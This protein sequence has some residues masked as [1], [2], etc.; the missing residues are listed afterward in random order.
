MESGSST[1]GAD[2]WV[3]RFGARLATLLRPSAALTLLAGALAVQTL[4]ALPPR[5]VCMVLLVAALPLA[6]A[7]GRTRWL[8]VALLGAAWT[9]LRADLALSRRLAPEL[10]GADVVL[11]GAVHGL[12]RVGEDG[13]HFALA[14]ERAER[15][16]REFVLDGIVRLGWYD[17]APA[18]EPCARWRLH[19][20]LKR[21]RGMIDP[22]AFD[23][24]RYALE[25]GIVAT[26]YV[27][28]DAVNHAV[29]AAAFCIDRLRARIGET[30][31][32]TLGDT[33]SAHLLR[34]LAF[35]DQH[36]MDEHEWAV[37]RATGI[38]HL[39]AISG[40]HIALFASFGVGLMRLLWKLAPRLTL[41]WPAP[42]LEAIASLACAVAYALI[43]GFGLPTRRAL[44][45]IAALLVANLARRAR[46]PV[47][48]LALAVI[49]L[50]AWDPLCVL[51][52][53]FWLSFVGVAWLLFC[54]GGARERRRWWR[55]LV[56]AQ[57]VAS[58][59]LLPL[60]IWFFGQSSLVGPLA[61]LV[62]VPAICLFILPLT[63]VAALLALLLPALGTPLLE[64]A[65]AAMQAL[66]WLLERMAAWP[67]ALRY[68]PEPDAWALALALVGAFWLLLPRG[69]PARALGAL[70]F[71]PLLWP[72]R[73][74][75]ADGEFVV[76]LLDVGQ[77]LAVI[78]R[79]REH[80]LV[81]DTGA[82]FPSG[83]DLGDAAVVP[84]LHALG[85]TGLDRIVLSHGDNDHAGGAAA[86]LAAFPGSPVESGE[87]ERVPIAASQCLAGEAWSW[88]GV[89]FRIVHPAPPLAERANDR[90][91]VLEVLSG[92]S[93]LVLPG[94]IT[95]AVEPAVA[96]AL[97]PAPS[98]LV[99]QVPHHGS[100]T[101][102]SAALLDGVHPTLALISAGYLNRFHHPHPD[103]VA[104]YRA[105]GATLLDTAQSGF[106]E[107]RFTPEAPPR[108][109]ARGRVDRHP[110]WRE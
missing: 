5:A 61:N 17:D 3:A 75:L 64:L 20:R 35:G 43:A 45:M 44:V 103:V 24:E 106:V 59:G 53:G 21:P 10:E 69:V 101:S 30:I 8:G 28:A 92:D 81:Y 93:A 9:M 79:T 60:G 90:C 40:L 12:P 80:A 100:K 76:D 25:Q 102:S 26:G 85:V 104:R 39:I 110:Y 18:L 38:P 23:F 19:A 57:G 82:R 99:L 74:A 72:A 52:A 96:A 13:T 16:G 50:L 54:L 37:A 71:L 63:V 77:G 88:D 84:A 78:V 1:R 47:Q 66:W 41:R 7:H 49:A 62:A 33:S 46:A 51:S 86:V 42:L 36:A 105:A 97:E 95:A 15:D 11:V 31:S 14:V 22:G 83:F 65:G 58:I 91:C 34:A 48:G 55:E 107:I 27:R 109:V 94:D 98:A 89:D 87:P 67:G 108:V 29:D 68:F 32:A 6:L 2:G 56:V 4:P 73:A 70:L